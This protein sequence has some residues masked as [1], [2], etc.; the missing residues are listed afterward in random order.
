MTV[1]ALTGSIGMGKSAVAAIFADE[2]VPVF[3]ADAV[4]H[5]LQG[6]GGR[7][8]D[9]IELAFPGST[10]PTGVDRARLGALV[11]GDP[12]KLKALEA[13]VHPVVA[14]ERA[15]FLEQ[16]SAAPLVVLDI[17]LL[18][19]KGA[20]PEIDAV[21]VVSAPADVQRTR[22]LAR[23][24][25]T[26]EKFEAIVALQTPDAEKRH[27]ADYIIETGTTLAATRTRV[28]EVIACLTSLQG[29]S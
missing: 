23:Q 12:G 5:A 18:F 27:R 24:G 21:A 7:L 25:M 6:P 13:I 28:R 29:S 14:S 19:E 17:P 20:P 9:A 3:D 22:V 15:A 1:L 11:F 8:V 16:H 4:V 2:N 26:P 10:G